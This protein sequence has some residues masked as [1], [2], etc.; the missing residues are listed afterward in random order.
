MKSPFRTVFLKAFLVGPKA[1]LVTSLPKRLLVF[2]S[3]I[4]GMSGLVWHAHATVSTSA[5][6]IAEAESN[7]SASDWANVPPVRP[8]PRPGKFAKPP[9]RPGYAS[10]LDLLADVQPEYFPD[11]GRGYYSLWDQITGNIRDTRPVS[12]YP[13]FALM[14]TSAY[15]IDFRYLEN[16]DHEKD[17]FDPV[18]RI[19]LGNDW[20]LSFGGSF[21]YRYMHETDSRLNAAGRNNDYHLIRTRFHADL[22]Y[23]DNLRL[24]A[25]FIDARSFGPELAPL[26]IDRNH[27]DI[28]NLFADYKVGNIYNS[29][30]YMRFGRQELIFGSQRLI[31]TLD[32]ANTRRT[33]QGIKSFW[34]NEKWDI[35]AFWVRPMK[36]E[37]GEF[38]NWDR[39]R[40]FFGLWTTY[41]HD[42]DHLI[43]LYFLSLN[44]NRPVGGTFLGNT[45]ILQS[46]AQGRTSMLGD[47]NVHTLGGRLVGDYNQ[48]L[49]EIEGM[50]QFGKWSNLDVSAFAVATGLGYD[51]QMP[52]NPILWLRYDF[53]SGDGNPQDGNVN[54]FNQLFPFGHYYLGYI[55]LIG[56]QNIHDF[57]AQLTLHPKRWVTFLAQYHRYYLANKRDFLYNAGGVALLGD[58]TGQSGSHVGDGIDF[59]VNIHVARHH[60]VL[61]GYSKLFS[62]NF[63][64]NQRPG[65]NPDLFYVQYNFRF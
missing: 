18:K 54:T 62:G 9:A 38:D 40:D 22:W 29:P 30:L 50:Y 34:R 48:I 52:L 32:W 55:D 5:D 42:K 27:T 47:S 45:D 58:P 16:P 60:D 65:I 64:E 11:P 7:W 33:F 21:W 28:L 2:G 8:M 61:V 4:A 24:F 17:I 57:N 46:A 44:D 49:Y 3:F 53:A 43:D 23:R 25:E 36:T 31:S 35:D 13:P 59:L 10:V 37:K 20:L 39:R 15:D 6:T 19:H 51:F 12:P 41:K 56:R 26:G 1:S 14:P 63:I